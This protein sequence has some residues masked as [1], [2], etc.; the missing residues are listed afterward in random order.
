MTNPVTI[1]GVTANGG[2]RVRGEIRLT[3]MSNGSP[4]IIPYWVINGIKPGPKLLLIAMT[5]GDAFVGF[6]SI[7]QTMASIDTSKLSGTVVCVPCAN[8][9]GFQ[10]GQRH[11]TIDHQNMNR[12]FP[13]FP[14][15]WFCDR[16]CAAI[17]PLFDICDVCI[18]WH[19]GGEGEA[20]NYINVKNTG[21]DEFSKR[22]FELSYAFGLEH[23]YSG[24]TAGPAH[25]YLGTIQD[26]F[27]SRKKHFVLAEIGSALQLPIDQIQESVTGVHNCM[28]FLGMEEGDIRLPKRQI[29]F[30]DRVLV[31]INEG[32]LFIPVL[33]PEM[34]NQFYPK[35]TLVYQIRNVL[36]GEITEEY[37]APFNNNLFISIRAQL[38]RVEPG[39]YS[40]IICD[41]DTAEIR[42]NE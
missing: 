18:D 21:D 11:C 17:S 14:D 6:E 4:C 3:H 25:Q 19:G 34:L 26:E 2:E 36:T 22:N 37:R 42:V 40:L 29:L 1:L 20:I 15:G 30:H 23:L 10:G 32:G 31:R 27:L 12:Q 5:H 41:M 33:G 24:K 9:A 28:R 8:P 35:D 39:D 16:L 38:G 13:G 7:W